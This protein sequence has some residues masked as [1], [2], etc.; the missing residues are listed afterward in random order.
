MSLFSY[1]CV[2]VQLQLCLCSATHISASYLGW[3]YLP[4][5]PMYPSPPPHTH[6]HSL[7]QITERLLESE[8][9]KLSILKGELASVD[10]SEPVGAS[11]VGARCGGGRMTSTVMPLPH[12]VVVG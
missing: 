6:K 12:L 3:K 1:S 9:R 8:E 4:V 2:S 5:V 7:L 10:Q 11:K